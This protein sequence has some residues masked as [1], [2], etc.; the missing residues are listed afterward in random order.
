[1]KKNLLKKSLNS[2]TVA[3]ESRS[4]QNV[5]LKGTVQRDLRGVKIGINR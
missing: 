3:P 5:I 4:A 1:M 2:H